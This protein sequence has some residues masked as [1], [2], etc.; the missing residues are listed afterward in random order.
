ML[1][2]NMNGLS[3]VVKG[4]RS[5]GHAEILLVS[6]DLVLVALL[7]C[8][9]PT[10]LV[11]LL[12]FLFLVILGDAEAHV[13]LKLAALTV[14]ELVKLKLKDLGPTLIDDVANDLDDSSLLLL[15]E[16]SH[17]VFQLVLFLLCHGLLINRLLKS[18]SD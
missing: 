14:R 10:S 6:C 7:L 4:L 9:L 1:R 17:V 16:L 5:R 3:L 11:S 18:L 12:A 13:G 8:G 2:L 15:R